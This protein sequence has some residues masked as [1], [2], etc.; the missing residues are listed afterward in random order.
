M[1]ARESVFEFA[2]ENP[3]YR[4]VHDNLRDMSKVT[5]RQTYV[6][7]AWVLHMLRA[8]IGDT[9]W[10]AGIRSYYRKY[11]N[12]T[13]T[14]RDFQREMEFAC[15]CDLDAYID[16][17]LYQGG[18]IELR[19]DW[20]Y[21]PDPGE[22]RVAISQLDE[23]APD[24]VVEIG[25]YSAGNPVPQVLPLKLEDGSGSLVV[26]APQRPDRVVIDPNTVLLAKWEFNERD[27]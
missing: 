8:R 3:D 13:A 1:E 24:A 18:N 23:T 27:I 17:W 6:K 2:A 16:R 9:D 12:A 25:I 26:D 4:I 19:G 10:W 22:V 11:R 7:G 14:T 21:V 15:A 20:H 5:T